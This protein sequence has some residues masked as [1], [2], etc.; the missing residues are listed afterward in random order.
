MHRFLERRVP[1]LGNNG[2]MVN[3]A[4]IP[5]THPSVDGISKARTVV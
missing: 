3:V 5:I 2:A 4:P 1:L